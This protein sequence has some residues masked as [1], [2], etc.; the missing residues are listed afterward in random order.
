MATK[1]REHILSVSSELF[2]TNGI[3]ATS[4]DTIVSKADIAKVTLYK[5]FKSK[6]DLILEYLRQYDEKMWAKLSSTVSKQKDSASKVKALAHGMLDWIGSSEFNGFAFINASVEFP[7]SESLVNQNSLIF[8]K[9]LRTKLSS[10]AQEAGWKNA[11]AIA[12]Q[13]VMVIE[14]AAITKRT[15]KKGSGTIAQAKALVNTLIEAAN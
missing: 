13:L 15:Q 10:L 14:G 5:Y 6:E 1:M 9:T 3:N 7:L 11:D 8:A 4:V 12:L 2:S